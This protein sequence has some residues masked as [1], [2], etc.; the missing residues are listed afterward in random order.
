MT[1][2]LIGKGILTQTCTEGQEDGQLQV[3][4]RGLRENQPAGALTSDF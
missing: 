1:G 4:E 3:K 2:V